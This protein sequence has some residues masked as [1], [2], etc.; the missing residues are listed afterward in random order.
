MGVTYVWDILGGSSLWMCTSPVEL[1]IH[2]NGRVL[3]IG[4]AMVWTSHVD[5]FVW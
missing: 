4:Q 2:L 3:D 5:F 1:E